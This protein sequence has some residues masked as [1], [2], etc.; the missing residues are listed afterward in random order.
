MLTDIPMVSP[1]SYLTLYNAHN[2]ESVKIPKP[3][4]F[5]S[6]NGLKSFIHESF[7]DYIISDIDNIFLLTSFGMKVKFNIINELNDIYVF[8]KRLFREQEMNPL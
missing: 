3:I 7:T 4:R 1:I 6:L 2:G 8:D 5:H